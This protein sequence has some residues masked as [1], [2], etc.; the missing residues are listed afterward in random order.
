DTLRHQSAQ[1][2]DLQD[3]STGG[4]VAAH[5]PS[6]GVMRGFDYAGASSSS[7]VKRP[8]EQDEQHH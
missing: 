3:R 5:I 7:R 6:A 4:N 1:R 2:H 8:A